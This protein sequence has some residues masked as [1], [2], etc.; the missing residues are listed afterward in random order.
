[1]Y[2]KKIKLE[3]FKT[4]ADKTEIEFPPGISCIVG[5]NGSGK[6]NIADAVRW[7]LGE[8]SIKSLRGSKL[9]EVIFA[10]SGS[11]KHVNFAEVSLF[12]DNTDNSLPVEYSEVCVVRR[13]HRSGESEYYINKTPC[14]LR[15]IQQLFLNTGLG[16]DTYSIIG[17]GEIETI[18][19]TSAQERRAIF[20]EAS[21]IN[22]YKYKK[23][24]AQKRLQETSYNLQRLQDILQEISLRLPTLKDESEKAQE[25]KKLTEELKGI[26]INYRGFKI[27]K[28][29]EKN[30]IVQAEEENIISAIKNEQDILSK[31]EGELQKEK[32][33]LITLEKEIEKI[34]DELPLLAKEIEKIQ[35]SI[36]V[37]NEKINNNIRKRQEIS[38]EIE[39]QQ[40][41]IATLQSILST[42]EKDLKEYELLFLSKKQEMEE[43]EKE[44][45]EQ[46]KV[47]SEE[48]EKLDNRKTIAYEMARE[49]VLKN[50]QSLHITKEI[51]EIQ[52]EI[53]KIQEDILNTED[54]IKK[55]END[56]SQIK[57]NISKTISDIEDKESKKKE[58]EV[59]SEKLQDEIF[60]VRKEKQSLSEELSSL[61]ARLSTIL[62]LQYGSSEYALGS[63]SVLSNPS[64]MEKGIIGKV[65]SLIKVSSDL[66]RAVEVALGVAIQYIVCKGDEI[67]KDALQYLKQEKKGRATFISLEFFQNYNKSVPQLQP[68]DG[69]IGWAKDIVEVQDE[70][71]GLINYLLHNVLLV[72]NIDIGISILN[73]TQE[74]IKVVTKDA[75]V[76]F[77]GVFSGGLY[78]KEKLGALSI[79]REIKEC[80]DQITSLRDKFSKKLKEEKQLLS[81]LEEIKNNIKNIEQEIS[82]AKDNLSEM[83]MQ[84]IVKTDALNRY[85]NDYQIMIE[86]LKAKEHNYSVLIADKE[87]L[88]VEI[89]KVKEENDKLQNEIHFIQNIILQNQKK[90]DELIEKLTSMKVDFAKIEQKRENQLRQLQD[91]KEQEKTLQKAI[92]DKYEMLKN[93]E[94]EEKIQRET[95]SNLHTLLERNKL[96]LSQKQNILNEYRHNRGIS[97]NI[98]KELEE[99]LS[100]IRKS[101]E[102]KQLQLH[103]IQIEKAQIEAELKE[104]I[105]HLQEDYSLSYEDICSTITEPDDAEKV[106]RTIKKLKSTILSLGP[107]NLLSIDEYKTQLQ[108]YE[109][110]ASQYEDVKNTYTLLNNFIK[111]L[112][113]KAKYIFLD[114]FHKVGL[115][116]D[117]IFQQIFGGGKAK[118]LLS[119][120]E[121]I[122]ES[123]VEIE[124]Q[125]PG[126]K[127]QN[128][129]LLSG[130]EKSLVAISLLFALLDVKPAPFCIFDEIDATLDDANL[131][132]FSHMLLQF[133]K[134][135]Q[136]III[137][138]AKGTMEVA[139][140]LWGVTMEEEGVSKVISVKLEDKEKQNQLLSS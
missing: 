32:E 124:V 64:L 72:E 116:F 9:E 115:S 33:Q 51:E 48:I 55:I 70:Y 129:M 102:E 38:Q 89:V 90:K 104:T 56:I 75:D 135:S 105:N 128:I 66:E 14:R 140:T 111:E 18:F 21:G 27:K 11:R 84:E 43:D 74:D 73:E 100:Q 3:G 139:Q 88:K 7:V 132:K 62:Q 137:T 54:N 86:N 96:Y 130:G 77:H 126:K 8:Q 63:K 82:V 119:D 25:Y 121:N 112:D 23:R 109:F 30:K 36:L 106:A 34:Q 2:L 93:Y 39:N 71:R 87:R 98:R 46:I 1:M 133:S 95:I 68:R 19:F 107:V 47:V 58:M 20:E 49:Y 31:I 125:I 53:K 6:S 118:L 65:S 80:K 5:P 131:K 50:N 91:V 45:T 123:G 16:R 60:K 28:M 15:D 134:N 79:E 17:Q 92:Q 108:R 35:G 114:I 117:R 81:Q 29:Q 26:D 103:K 67:A 94:E 24:E 127:V 44:L 120:P 83:Q 122:F 10:G 113:M 52:Q 136:F 69:I 42:L 22:K 110:L 12:I 41:Q 138:H 4:F 57:N 97:Y 76:L 85:K 101:L 37:H 61:E 78:T 59:E 40:R 99:N 13:I